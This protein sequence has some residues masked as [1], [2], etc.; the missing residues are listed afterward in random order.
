MN[1]VL[2]LGDQLDLSSSAFDDFDQT[3]DVVWMAEVHSE[4]V[5]VWNHKARITIFLSAMRH[6]RDELRR[7]GFRV[8]YRELDDV[9]NKGSFREELKE[10]IRRHKPR[11]VIVVEPGEYRV[12][13]ELKQATAKLEIRTDRHFFSTIDEFREHAKGRKQLRL[14]YF[15]RD[16]RRRFKILMEK[17]KPV[18]GDWNYDAENR[19][20][21]PKAG[22]G[23]IRSPLD[24][25]K[26]MFPPNNP[27][28][29]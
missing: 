18:G 9:E 16:M 10:A 12:C 15:Y 22:P 1:L 17:D 14:E 5:H 21:L 2:I 25:E 23:L 7:R 26:Q 6:F 29:H 11:R 13:D 27:T 24:F 4:A 28:T 19:A 3:R 8:D 20:S